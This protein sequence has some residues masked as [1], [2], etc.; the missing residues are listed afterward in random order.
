MEL[1]E[2]REATLSRLQDASDRLLV[3]G[4]DTRFLDD[5]MADDARSSSLSDIDETLD[6]ENI[7]DESPRAERLESEI[8]SE[9]ETER[10]DDSPNH[11]RNK[12]S[13]VLSAAGTYGTSP[14]KLAQSTTYDDLDEEGNKAENSPSKPPR[15]GKSNGIAAGDDTASVIGR[16]HSL[17]TSREVIGK[18]RKRLNSG[19]DS[20]M[21]MDEDEH[22]RK[23]R[24]SLPPDGPVD[25]TLIDVSLPLVD[26]ENP[27]KNSEGSNDEAFP[28]DETPDIEPTDLAPR[29]KK[30]KK[31]KRKGKKIKEVD[32][33]VERESVA[34]GEPE[35]NGAPEDQQNEEEEPA[36]AV[37]EVD[38]AET[39]SKIEEEY[40]RKTTAMDLLV[41]LEKQFAT[42]R[43]K[44]YD[45]RI[46][47]LNNELAQLNDPNPTHPE[48]LR[49]LGVLENY[50][51]EKIK[52]EKTLFAYKRSS[53]CAKS[54]AERCQVN[55]SYFQRARDVREQHLERI[56][57]LQY[58]IQQDRFQNTSASPDYSIP[59]PMR[60]SQQIAQ[61]SAYNREVSVLSGLAKYVGFPSAPVMQPARQQEMDEDFE[62]M[63]ISTRPSNTT[64][65]TF[66]QS[67]PPSIPR[68]S[69]IP[70]TS[71]T[72][73]RPGAEE[74]FL[75][76]TPWAN[77][78]HPIHEPYLKRVGL[79]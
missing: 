67:Q 42:L 30:G 57:E 52:H 61:Q 76:E 79:K 15:Y 48:F 16:R 39:V 43:D 2:A 32:D 18:K 45:E 49:Q 6:T 69:F 53:L 23:R 59:F 29:G 36:E 62:K 13:I 56:S 75:E 9:A 74:E 40:M 28:T 7:Y 34:P 46:A 47:N 77:P 37:E 12:T 73:G 38:D 19:E 65:T 10:I 54:Q 14:S 20:G 78:Q 5:D 4:H 58:R 41:N 64:T 26:S 70:T 72:G 22:V 27:P 3:N 63:G 35:G 66:P 60:R 55:S 25:E 17:S 71:S 1:A 24:A 44:I 50:R 68:S 33:E 11:T 51:D 21:D 8:D 31:G